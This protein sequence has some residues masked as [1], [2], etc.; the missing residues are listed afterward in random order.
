M[1]RGGP[2]TRLCAHARVV[3][4]THRPRIF[5]EVDGD[6]AT[7]RSAGVVALATAT[8]YKIARA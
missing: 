5:Y 3:R 4:G 2:R 7:G 6:V 1:I 8:G